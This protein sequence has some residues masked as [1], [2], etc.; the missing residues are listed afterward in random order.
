MQQLGLNAS[1][2][3]PMILVGL[4][5][6]ACSTARIQTNRVLSIRVQQSTP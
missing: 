4:R 5:F 2:I 6:D 1:R 3:H